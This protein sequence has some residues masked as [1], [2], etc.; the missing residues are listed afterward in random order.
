[1]QAS[2]GQQQHQQECNGYQASCSSTGS[3]PPAALGASLG[4]SFGGRWQQQC[5]IQRE[6][7]KEYSHADGKVEWLYDDGSREVQYVNGSSQVHRV[8]GSVL[9]YFGNGDVKRQWA[10]GRTDYYYAEVGLA[11]SFNWLPPQHCPAFRRSVVRMKQRK[12]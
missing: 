3:P 10:S 9:V 2:A 5:V 1:V 6:V 4:S 11:T 8:D 12:W 7:L